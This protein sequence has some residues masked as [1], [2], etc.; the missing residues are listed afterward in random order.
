MREAADQVDHALFLA[1]FA[2]WRI[3]IGGAIGTAWLLALMFLYLEP[4]ASM[5]LWAALVTLVFASIGALCWIYEK[6]RPA[7]GSPVQRRWLIT[8]TLFCGA[9][10]FGTGLL[11]WFIPAHR[12]ELQL[13]AAALVSIL[14]IAFVVSRGYRSVI[15]AIVIGHAIGLSLALALHAKIYLAVPVALLFAAFVLSFGLMLNGAM[16]AAIA[17]RLYAQ[18]LHAQ[19]QRSLAR[20]LQQLEATLHERRRVLSDLHDGFG[21][22]LLTSLSLLERGQIATADAAVVLRECLDD[23]RLMIDAHEPAARN[24]ATLLGMLR[25][26][27]QRR[28]EA[29]GIQMSWKIGEL[30][31]TDTLPS[32][33]ALDLLRL[34]QEAIANV[35]QHA[36]ARQIV[37]STRRSPRQLEISVED[38]GHGFDPAAM[39]NGNGIAGMQR[40]AARLGGELTIDSGSEGGTAV[41]LALR[42]PLGGAAPSTARAG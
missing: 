34:L 1:R 30:L 27:L 26:R 35:L 3:S 39:S 24:P 9:G 33:Q 16:R 22:Q 13:S 12:D 14:S 18:H 29:A 41:R 19:L 6:R 4:G 31:E 7:I 37:V 20:Q 17:Q 42:L 38:D 23:L 25:Y 11:P 40:R 36:G 21:S 5:L 8:W 32:S 2:N 28:I 15:Y 10:G